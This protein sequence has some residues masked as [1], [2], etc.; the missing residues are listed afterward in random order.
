[1]PVLSAIMK[2][3]PSVS[4]ASIGGRPNVS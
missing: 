1:L 2:S 3:D 4:G